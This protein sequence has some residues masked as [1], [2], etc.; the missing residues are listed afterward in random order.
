M[1]DP[2]P[3]PLRQHTESAQFAAKTIPPTLAHF[4]WSISAA[5]QFWLSLL[6]VTAAF[7]DTAPIEVQRRIVNDTIKSGDFNAILFLAFVYLALVTGE[8][9]VK[10][11]MSVYRGWV[12]EN[13]TR[14]LRSNVGATA[15]GGRDTET[16]G[17]EAAMLLSE[18][19]PIGGF[20]GDS[21]SEPLLQFGILI[22]VFAYLTYL[23]WVMAL[24]SFISFLPQAL[25]VPIMQRA[26]NARVRERIVTLRAT[27]AGAIDEHT[28]AIR[29]LQEARFERVFHLNMGIL[30]LKYS[31]NFLMNLTQHVG[32]VAILVLGGWYVVHGV[33]EIGTVIAF[34]SGMRNV[35]DPWGSIIN[36]VQN[37]WVTNAKYRMLL[38]AL[39]RIET[40][41]DA[42]PRESLS[43]SG[44]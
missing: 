26:I 25:F 27:G 42:G 22:T 2:V 35:T 5:D 39:S 24:V 19:E 32:T 3:S 36:W 37:A 21:V 17:I 41:A 7:L 40:L 20:V 44:Q 6:S 9:A 28:E 4:I 13:A 23:H 11:V 31:L 14:F 10:L 16:R 8:G 12:S 43:P 15:D 33:S 18:A 34:L 30:E 38:G 29:L 1:F